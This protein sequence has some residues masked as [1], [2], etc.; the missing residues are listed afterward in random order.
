[1]RGTVPAA[2]LLS[3]CPDHTG[4]TKG[5]LQLAQSN[6]ILGFSSSTM[7]KPKAEGKQDLLAP[8]VRALA[9]VL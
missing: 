3:G 5:T 1:M 7:A 6:V 9:T 4:S 2:L 8:R